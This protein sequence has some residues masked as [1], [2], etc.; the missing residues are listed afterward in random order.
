MKIVPG[1]SS[2]H[3]AD[4]I[5]H[6]LGEQIIPIE[7]KRF[8]DGEMYIRF[9]KE[10]KGE[11]VV[12]VQ[13]TGPPQDE[14]LI[15]L[16]LLI[17][18]ARD[19][20]ARSIIAVVPYVAYGRQMQRHRPGEA[21]SATTVF[22]LLKNAG[23]DY[24]ITV[25]YH[26]PE[27]INTIGNSV[28]NISAIPSLAH[29]MVQNNLEDAFSLAPDKGAI[30]FAETAARIMKGGYSWLEK[31]RDIITGEVTFEL[32]DL[33]VKNKDAVVFDDIISTGSTMVHAIKA[34]KKQGA[35]RVYAA[36]VHP[37][38]INNAKERISQAGAI[39]IV[40][41]DSVPSSVSVVSI[42]PVITEALKRWLK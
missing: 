35:R 20:G 2:K 9:T 8:P 19:L 28:Q 7:F 36:C 37:L 18:T 15:Q 10:V 27:T 16:L 4:K 41:T 42:A 32:R 11:D 12:I 25:D 5:S 39:Q 40:G 21:V 13:S 26:S 17:D 3:L 22:K 1:T 38:L 31:N 23:V 30:K 34:L 14:N 24:F 29:F 6:L 33:D